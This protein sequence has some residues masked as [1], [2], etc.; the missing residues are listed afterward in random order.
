MTG[1]AVTNEASDFLRFAESE[2]GDGRSRL[3][4]AIVSYENDAGIAVDLVAAVHVG[5]PAYY[6]ALDAH[7][8]TYDRVLY[9]LVAPEGTRPQRGAESGGAVGFMQ[10]SMKSI[11]ELEF[12]LDGVD[13]GAR[14]FVHADL[15]PEGLARAQR[16]RGESVWAILLNVWIAEAQ[17]AAQGKGATLTLPELYAAFTAEDRASS[18]KRL[19]AEQFENMEQMAAAFDVGADGSALVTDRN[20]AALDVLR[21]EVR[22]GARSIAIFY[23]AAHMADFE[24]RLGELGFAKTGQRWLTA[25]DIR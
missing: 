8:A 23:G 13:Y 5:D 12:Q 17:R 22:K 2:A 4:T 20:T 1:P 14:N 11:L 3:E 6:D 10:R 15:D 7:F 19:L 18:M 24:Q 9:E 16:E 25:W 21:R